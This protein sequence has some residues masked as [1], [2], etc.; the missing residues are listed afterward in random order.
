MSGRR[1][2]GTWPSRRTRSATRRSRASASIAAAFWPFAD[3]DE[4]DSRQAYERLD[5]HAMAL[6][7][8]EI[9]D[10]EKRWSGQA[11][12]PSRSVAVGRPEEGGIDSIA[13][14]VHTLFGDPEIGQPLFQPSRH[15]DQ[16]IGM[17]CRPAD[18][19][20]RNRIFRD[21]V[22]IAAP[23]GDDNWASKGASE[24]H[25][26]DAVRIEIM[27]VDQ[28]EIP[29]A[30]ELP[31]QNRQNSGEKGEWRRAH[32]DLRQLR[33]A[34]IID[35]QSISDLFAWLPGKER[36]VAESW[37]RERKPRT[38]RHDAGSDGAAFRQLSQ[39]GFDEDPVLG[40]YLA[41]IQRRKR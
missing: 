32:A 34:R 15:R 3:D 20:S 14:H 31:A 26:S 21:D 6:Q 22:E 33:I 25:R 40:S 12:S 5:H 29:S 1:S 24:Q 8:D 30:A 37:G 17:P 41:R 35:M 36:I 16:P 7:P 4:I 19:A 27:R 2:C 39:P 11:K 23:G 18:P 10:G 13:Q 28:I 9:A 38:G